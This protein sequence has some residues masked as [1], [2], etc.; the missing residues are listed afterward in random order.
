MCALVAPFDEAREEIRRQTSTHGRFVLIHVAT[1]LDV[2][3]LRDPKGLYAR[4]RAGS[5]ANLTG[6]GEEYEVPNNAD[7][8]VDMTS[9]T[10]EDT[11]D[12]ICERLSVV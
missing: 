3:S 1:P 8:V 9:A 6:V 11:A 12:T 2:C 4:A 5:I 10:V 7:F